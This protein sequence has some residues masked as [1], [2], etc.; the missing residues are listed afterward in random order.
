MTTS[1]LPSIVLLAASWVSVLNPDEIATE[2]EQ[3][4][5]FLESNMQD[6][7]PRQRSIRAVFD[8]SSFIYQE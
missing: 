1:T 5:D 3:S 8:R 2:I 4:L 6:V 7:P